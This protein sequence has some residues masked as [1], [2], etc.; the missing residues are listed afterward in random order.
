MIKAMRVMISDSHGNTQRVFVDF[1]EIAAMIKAA[2]S[3]ST[4]AVEWKGQIKEFS[5]MSYMTRADLKF[6]FFQRGLD[7]T[8]FVSIG[9]NENCIL[10]SVS[11]IK[12]IG[13][14]AAKCA[15]KVNEKQQKLIEE[16][17]E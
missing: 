2:E 5:E 6:G 14:N 7:Q 12:V 1:D 15:A 8:A 16:K 3:M 4:A 9:E 10:K 11:D 13:E 17:Q